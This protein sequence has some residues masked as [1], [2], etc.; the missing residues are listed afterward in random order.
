MSYQLINPTRSKL[1]KNELTLGVGLVQSRTVDIASM[2][3]TAGFDWLFIDLEHG[4]LSTETACQISIAALQSNITPIVRIPINGYSMVS[5]ILDGGAMGIVLPHVESP[6]D[7]LKLVD[8]AKFSPDGHRGVGGAIAQFQYQD[9][10]LPEA[11]K[12]LNRSMLLVAMVET[13][14]AID[15]IDEIASVEGIDIVMIGTND[16]AMSLGCPQ[17]FGNK[18]VVSCYEKVA[19]SCEKH[20]KWLGSGGVKIPEVAKQYIN[21]GANFFLAGQDI[22]FLMSAAK[23]RVNVLRGD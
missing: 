13:P 23:E 5:R 3:S 17:D 20:G 15:R 4:A 2:M 7:A 18:K 10:K 8:T 22:G 9:V 21:M 19:L 12:E 14:E 6:E 1:E 16:L 11:V